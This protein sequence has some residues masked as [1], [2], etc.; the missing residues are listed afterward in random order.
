MSSPRIIV[1]STLAGIVLIMGIWQIIS[2][3]KIVPP[4]TQ[5]STE[6]MSVH[7]DYTKIIDPDTIDTRITLP[8]Y[9]A[10]M[11]GMTYE[12]VRDVVGGTGLVFNHS[13]GA[14][15]DIIVYTYYGS[16][17][18]SMAYITLRDGKLYAKNQS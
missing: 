5:K 2:I 6:S 10:L 8:E 1:I 4:I 15:Y 13:V 11:E 9:E 7:T 12:Q 17:R 14:T 3:P 16:G 18:G